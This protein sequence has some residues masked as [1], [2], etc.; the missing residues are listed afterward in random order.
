MIDLWIVGSI[1]G[2]LSVICG[3]VGMNLQKYSFAKNFDL[4]VEIQRPYFKQPLWVIGFFLSVCDYLFLLLALSI[5]SQS[6]IAP[7]SAITFVSNVVF[8]HFAL[9]EYMNKV[10]IS[11]SL[12]IS[13]GVIMAAMLG[14]HTSQ[15]YTMDDIKSLFSQVRFVVYSFV[16]LLIVAVMH[17]YCQV[18][19]PLKTRLMQSYRDYERLE[20]N[21]QQEQIDQQHLLIQRLEQQYA[22]YEKLHRIC[23]CGL[24]GV[25]GGH[26][27]MLAK[28]IASLIFTSCFQKEQIVSFWFLLFVIS[29]VLCTALQFY[30]LTS[31]LKFF[32][33]ITCC[34]L[35][36]HIVFQSNTTNHS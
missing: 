18:V 23:L 21:H 3:N 5:T 26:A 6:I 29:L 24:S 12:I 4:G 1:L 17:Y 22:K 36:K 13:I 9:H 14:N 15:Q 10:R 16:M 20:Q 30:F 33:C 19:N 28:I 2:C 35:T 11:G 25:F 8:G 32:D 34:K 31:V 7:M 27:L